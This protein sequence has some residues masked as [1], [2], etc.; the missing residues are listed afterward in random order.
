MLT[1]SSIEWTETTWNPTTGCSKIS[2]G[3]AHC[4]AERMARR[5]KAMG[6]KKYKQ[7]FKFT[8]HPDT[9]DAPLKIKKSRKIFVN[10]MSDLFHEE[11]PLE[12][13]KKVF[14]VMNEAHWHTFQIVTKRH[15]N[16]LKMAKH[17][18][19]SKNIWL[20]VTVEHADY[21]DRIRYL[22]KVP[23]AVRFISAEPLLSALP[24]MPLQK[25]DW[26]IVGGESGWNARP[27]QEE[28]VL[29]IQKQC[30][31]ANAAFFFKQWGGVNKKKTGSK[32]KGKTWK[33][34]P[35]QKVSTQQRLV[36]A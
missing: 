3:C 23:A 27:I 4:Y 25:I 17:V 36:F 19:W 34:F 22:E 35:A 6:V 5:L 9:L 12:Y 15:E 21:I 28:W 32:L 30:Q 16:M 18:K 33:A 31:K 26:V 14:A 8:L 20:G 10:S 29:D 24:K 7:G 1:T 2:S 11:M 13:L